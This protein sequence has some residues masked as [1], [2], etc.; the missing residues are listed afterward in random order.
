MPMSF[1]DGPLSR[2]LDGLEAKSLVRAMRKAGRAG[3]KIGGS[4][5]VID[6]R[7]RRWNPSLHPRDSRGR[8]IETGG[9]AKVWGGGRGKVVRALGNGRVELRM[10]DGKKRVVPA[11]RLT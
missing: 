10:S 11:R 6:T 4:G 7:G 1:P 2:L 5:I 9:I 8:F 3:G